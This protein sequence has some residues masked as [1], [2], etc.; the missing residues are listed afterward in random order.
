MYVHLTRDQGKREREALLKALSYQSSPIS[1]SLSSVPPPSPPL[2][3]SLPVILQALCSPFSF[4]NDIA[5]LSKR[6]VSA[7]CSFYHCS[8]SQNEIGIVQASLLGSILA[9]LLLILGMCFLIGGLRYREQ[10]YDY[11]LHDEY[12]AALL[13]RHRFIIA[14]S[15]R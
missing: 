13:T 10:V 15:R 1:S 2:P 12:Q 9:N 7:P 3:P 14:P 4:S 6:F 8:S 5:L 11:S